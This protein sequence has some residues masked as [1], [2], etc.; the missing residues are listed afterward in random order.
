MI[1]A[2]NTMRQIASDSTKFFSQPSA[3][4]LTAAFRQIGQS[5][6]TTRILDDNTQ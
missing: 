6:L 1:S 4:D 3:G 2:Y 5:L